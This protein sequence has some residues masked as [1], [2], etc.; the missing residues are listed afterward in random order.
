MLSRLDWHA[1]PDSRTETSKINFPRQPGRSEGFA[2]LDLGGLP[3][4][5]AVQRRYR[6][7]V[8]AD[9]A[10]GAL[11]LEVQ[12]AGGLLDADAGQ[13]IKCGYDGTALK[14]VWVVADLRSSI[15]LLI[16]LLLDF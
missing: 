1:A 16:L 6:A 10:A 3:S 7:A 8:E 13:H 11:P 2:N 4:A 5:H 12:D 15:I 14:Q 9:A